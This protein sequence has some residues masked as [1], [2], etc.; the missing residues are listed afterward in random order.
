MGHMGPI[1]RILVIALVAMLVYTAP[2][3]VRYPTSIPSLQTA[4]RVARTPRSPSDDD[5][6]PEEIQ[7]LTAP[8]PSPASVTAGQVE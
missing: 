2:A 8:P 5:D 7:T 3:E 1:A 4:S 6:G